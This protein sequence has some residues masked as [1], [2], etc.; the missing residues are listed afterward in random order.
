MSMQSL[1]RLPGLWPLFATP[2]YGGGRSKQ[3]GRLTSAQHELRGAKPTIT[4]GAL[5]AECKDYRGGTLAKRP[6]QIMASGRRVRIGAC[7]ASE[8]ADAFL[9]TPWLSAGSS[10]PPKRRELSR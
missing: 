1:L 9:S 6:L 5:E 10:H 2:A 7:K 3:F 8:P 4:D